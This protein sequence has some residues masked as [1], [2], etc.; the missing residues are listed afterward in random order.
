MTTISSHSLSLPAVNVKPLTIHK[1]MHISEAPQELYNRFV[2]AQERFLEMKYSKIPDLSQNPAYQDYAKILV[3][4]KVVAEIDNNG[5]VKSSN[6]LGAL[7]KD[8]LPGDVNGQTG[9]VL[10]QA[11]AEII[12]KLTGGRIAASSTAMTQSQFKATPKPTVTVDYKAML[13]DAL[14]EQLEKTKEARTLY[15]AQQIGQD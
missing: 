9:P 3:G 5:A 7:L 14:Y 1:A 12:A 2:S 4:G 11:R 10:A 6:A 15:L 13:Q 8:R